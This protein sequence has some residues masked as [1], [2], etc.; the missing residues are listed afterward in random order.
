M[1][2]LHASQEV[3]RPLVAWFSLVG[4][5]TAVETMFLVA[6]TSQERSVGIRVIPSVEMR[7]QCPRPNT[8]AHTSLLFFNA[9]LFNI[10]QSESAL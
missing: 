3:L 7:L 1:N 5:N 8:V 2:P 10:E 6:V 9:N 4:V